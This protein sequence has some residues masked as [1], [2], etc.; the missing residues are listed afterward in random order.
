VLK[1]GYVPWV[2]KNKDRPKGLPI[3]VQS[4]L[5]KEQGKTVR[6][7]YPSLYKTRHCRRRDSDKEQQTPLCVIYLFC[8]LLCYPL[9]SQQSCLARLVGD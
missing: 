7:D 4:N 5:Q 9:N 2:T 3:P 8:R 6:K 1:Y